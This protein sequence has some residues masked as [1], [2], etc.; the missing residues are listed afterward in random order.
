[1]L[2]GLPNNLIAKLQR[3]QNAA[4]RVIAGVGKREHVTPLLEQLHW[5]PVELRIIFKVNLLTYKCLHKLAP[6]YLQELLNVYRP[7][8]TLRSSNAAPR[9]TQKSYCLKNYGYRAFAVHAPELWNKLP[10]YI[11]ES[12][13]VSV[14][15]SR[16]KTYLFKNYF[17]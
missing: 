7:N 3:V 5:L 8:R 2:Y 17:N 9:L 6:T 10:S 15:K 1:M 11:R 16:L 14:F 12:E 4:A 13:S